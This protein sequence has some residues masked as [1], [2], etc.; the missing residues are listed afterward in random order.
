MLKCSPFPA[1]LSFSS[2]A[3]SHPTLFSG[4]EITHQLFLKG[5]LYTSQS[6]SSMSS[7][8]VASA[9]CDN[10]RLRELAW[11]SAAGQVCPPSL[12]LPS[13]VL[14]VVWAAFRKRIHN[15]NRPLF[16]YLVT[17]LG[18]CLGIE[19]EVA[20]HACACLVGIELRL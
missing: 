4:L 13:F 16:I 12:H 7:V 8:N 19:E 3:A 1:S 9:A 5:N 20:G 2:P 15:P 10:P 14:A 6:K 18:W 17:G 11:D